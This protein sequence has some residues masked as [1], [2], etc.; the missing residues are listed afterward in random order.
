M[1]GY[2]TRVVGLVLTMLLLFGSVGVPAALVHNASTDTTPEDS[3]AVAF[4]ALD[5]LGNPTTADSLLVIVSGPSGAVVFQDSLATTD[6]RITTTTVT[7]CPT[8]TFAD[9]AAS[10]GGSSWGGYRIVLVARNSSLEL[11]T[12]TQAEFQVIGRRLAPALDLIDDTLWVRGGAIDSNRTERGSG[13]SAQ[14]AGWVWNTPQSGHV[15]AGTFGDYLDADVSGLGSG[16]GAYSVTVVAFDS[17]SVQPVPGAGVAVR[18]LSQTTLIASGATDTEGEVSFNLDAAE[19]SLV[20]SCPGYVFGPLDTLQVA[21][22]TVDTARGYRFDPG[23]PA[24]PGLCRVYGYVYA[25]DATPIKG[26]RVEARLPDS[27]NAASYL[28]VAPFSIETSTGEDG[29][30]A[31]DLIP[32]ADLLPVATDYEISIS[33][34]GRVLYRDRVTVPSEGFF[35]LTP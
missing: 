26:A 33:A 1:N 32:S 31:L 15:T 19:Y 10:L 28:F 24:L 16:S 13:D 7:G 30:F 4:C 11:E 35:R 2:I 6:E 3:V 5:S 17:G 25:I 23:E 21:G 29:Y 14:I 34:N 22:S 18:N 20:A 8:Y 9:L 12:V 27:V